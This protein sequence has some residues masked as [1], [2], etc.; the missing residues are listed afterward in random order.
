[1]SDSRAAVDFAECMR[2][3]TDSEFPE[4][5]ELMWRFMDL[6]EGVHERCDDSNGAIG[7]VFRD[8]CRDL[9]PLILHIGETD[10]VAGHIGFE[11]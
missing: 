1:L 6:A 3:L 2:E 10:C 4:A 8:A 7:D 11:L 5:L 9:G